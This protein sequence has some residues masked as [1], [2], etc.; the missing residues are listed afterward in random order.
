MK[1]TILILAAGVG[2]SMAI[3]SCKQSANTAAT[4][5]KSVAKKDSVVRKDSTH[6]IG[7]WLDGDIK[8]EK[9]E[10]VAYELVSQ[11]TKTYIQVITFTEKKLNID[12]NPAISPSAMELK[13]S[14]NKYISLERANEIY[15]VNAAGELN[16]YDETGIIATCKRM[17]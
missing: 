7:V 1:N 9:G 17:L 3:A 11:G 8:T 14:G 6:L 4:T 15:M 13:K 16:I 2:L 5:N 10:N 12:E